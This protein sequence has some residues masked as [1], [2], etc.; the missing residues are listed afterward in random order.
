MSDAEID[1]E[2]EDTERQQQGGSP[3]LHKV[4]NGGRTSCGLS[5]PSNPM[6]TK[7]DYNDKVEYGVEEAT[8]G[9][10]MTGEHQNT[11]TCA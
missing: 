10:V 4:D 1:S 3:L 6:V 2:A 9:V 5:G 7:D 8:S 11:T